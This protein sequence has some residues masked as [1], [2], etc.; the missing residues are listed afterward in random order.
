MVAQAFFICGFLV[1]GA[2]LLA[3]NSRRP[4]QQIHFP[5]MSKDDQALLGAVVSGSLI[6]KPIDDSNLLSGS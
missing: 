4:K 6:L 3:T 1:A 5:K 2:I